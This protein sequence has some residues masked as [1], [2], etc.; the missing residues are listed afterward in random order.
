MKYTKNASTLDYKFSGLQESMYIATSEDGNFRIYSWDTEDGGSM[1]RFSRV[2]QYRTAGG[3]VYS[4]A[5]AL[6][7]GD[8]GID[9]TP[10]PEREWLTE[11]DAWLAERYVV[12]ERLLRKDDLVAR[13][14]A[15]GYTVEE[16]N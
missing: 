3:K 10:G 15:A 8:P 5:D 16:P 2:Y 11:P 14:R 4:K 1:H 12:I 7:E 13:W 6:P 9:V